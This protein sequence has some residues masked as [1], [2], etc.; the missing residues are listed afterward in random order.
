M[1]FDVGVVDLPA[2]YRYGMKAEAY[3]MIYVD[4]D[5]RL[6]QDGLL[7]A[8]RLTFEQCAKKYA[9]AQRGEIALQHV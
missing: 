6:E 9:C 1:T 2:S 5:R 7:I 4:A 8:P 3:N